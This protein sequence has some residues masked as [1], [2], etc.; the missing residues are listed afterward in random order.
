MRLFVALE[1]SRDSIQAV[2]LW[3]K[4]LT[5][6]YPLLKWVS[7]EQLH[8]TLR[9]LG[10]CDPDDVISQ[11]KSLALS[12]LLPVEYTL[13]DTGRFGKPP[14]AI[15]LSGMFSSSLFTMVRRLEQISGGYGKTDNTRKFVPHVTIARVKTGVQCPQL[16]FDTPIDGVARSVSLIESVPAPGGPVYSTLYSVS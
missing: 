3:R 13:S 8:V 1:L 4:P 16:K 2:E 5:C 15:W 12:E 10:N 9:F 6:K 11:M 7:G 14:F